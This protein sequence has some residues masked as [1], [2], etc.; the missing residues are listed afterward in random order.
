[1]RRAD[2][3]LFI[4]LLFRPVTN[5]CET[6][7]SLSGWTQELVRYQMSPRFKC[8]VC[9]D[10]KWRDIG[11]PAS[12]GW[13]GNGDV[14]LWHWNAH[15][16]IL[17]FGSYF[18]IGMCH[19]IC[20]PHCILVQYP[21]HCTAVLKYGTWYSEPNYNSWKLVFLSC[22]IFKNQK[23]T[24]IFPLL[25]SE[26]LCFKIGSVKQQDRLNVVSSVWPKIWISR[27]NC[28]F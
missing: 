5:N 20:C 19:P 22:I 18:W 12:A 15:Y 24:F 11:W 13:A 7:A 28:L 25:V 9:F 17:L 16:P 8:A 26:E 27:K 2:S 1:M 10:N 14:V 6:S 21:C 3:D 4:Y 23:S